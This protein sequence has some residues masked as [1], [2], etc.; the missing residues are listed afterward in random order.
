MR[1]SQYIQIWHCTIGS[2]KNAVSEAYRTQAAFL[3]RTTL[4]PSDTY[5]HRWKYP[6]MRIQ[7]PRQT[8]HS[9]V[10]HFVAIIAIFLR[11][12]PGSA[13]AVRASANLKHREQPTRVTIET[14][15]YHI[16]L[17]MFEQKKKKMTQTWW[18]QKEKQT[19]TISEWLQSRF[20]ME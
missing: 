7:Y 15:I 1:N 12:T 5:P 17:T 18:E 8:H 16:N 2:H 20:N 19:D 11:G 14:G 4:L 3:Y 9:L 10:D 13:S 6:Q